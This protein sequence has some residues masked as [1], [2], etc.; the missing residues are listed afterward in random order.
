VYARTHIV[1][2]CLPVYLA[3]TYTGAHLRNCCLALTYPGAH[4]LFRSEALTYVLT[5][6]GPRRDNYLV[7]TPRTPLRAILCD[8]VANG[9]DC[10]LSI[11]G[12]GAK[13]VGCE[14][15]RGRIRA[16]AEKLVCS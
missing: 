2:A 3:L 1:A 9:E 16:G 14:A 15:Q 12:R 10:G 8:L 13:F 4:L 5:A 7:W 6:L 11:V